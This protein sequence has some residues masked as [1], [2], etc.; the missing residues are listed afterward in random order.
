MASTSR[1][2][3]NSKNK[4]GKTNR[5]HKKNV[6]NNKANSKTRKRIKIRYGRVFLALIV[7]GLILYLFFY[8]F[9]FNITNIYVSGN[10]YLTDQELIE[11][12]GLQDYPSTL[13]NT[14]LS[15]KHK[16]EKHDLI[17]KVTV[18]KNGLFQVSIEIEE[19]SPLFYNKTISKFVL[20]NKKEIDGKFDV[21]ILIN[22]VPDKTYQKFI[23]KMVLVT[24]DILSRISEIEYKPN[25]VDTN[26]FL[27]S[28][29]DGNY[30]YLTL[31]KFQN[32]NNYIEIV[33][34]F[35]KKKGILYLDSGEYF[36]VYEG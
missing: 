3:T 16:L 21:P 10:K 11:L 29:Q 18:K 12:S 9:R 25:D 33:R 31:N 8:F 13:T 22:Y 19:N 2:K 27:L 30:V 20:S 34:K 28:M 1:K 7:I 23:K 24:P 5:K 26:R 17:K 14:C 36:K 4:A 32:I 35:E 6:R 15:I